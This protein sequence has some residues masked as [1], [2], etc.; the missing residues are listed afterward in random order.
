MKAKFDTI[1]FYDLLTEIAEE[2]TLK[3]LY[4]LIYFTYVRHKTMQN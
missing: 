2:V 4:Y 1:G 3:V